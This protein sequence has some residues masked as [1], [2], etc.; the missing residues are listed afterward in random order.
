LLNQAFFFYQNLFNNYLILTVF[1]YINY[2]SNK[3]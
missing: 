1:L 3:N 2:L